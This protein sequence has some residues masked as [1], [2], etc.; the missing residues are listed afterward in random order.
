MT[1]DCI[2]GSSCA[3]SSQSSALYRHPLP[4]R[5][6]IIPLAPVS[7]WRSALPSLAV[8]ALA[9]SEIG[10]VAADTST[11]SFN[12]CRALLNNGAA[13]GGLR[14]R[15][16]GNEPGSVYCKKPFGAYDFK[17]PTATF[18]KTQRNPIYLV[19]VVT[20]PTK[21]SAPSSLLRRKP[22]D[23]PRVVL[24]QSSSTLSITTSTRYC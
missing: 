5:P 8:C 10:F 7:S 15:S 14:R 23:C 13:G 6:T 4:P 9:P 16:E 18:Q 3:S 1:A 12:R 22:T 19:F 11:T 17:S 21:G 2:T 24:L 20:W